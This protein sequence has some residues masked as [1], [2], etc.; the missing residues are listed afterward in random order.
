MNLTIEMYNDSRVLVDLEKQELSVN[1]VDEDEVIKQLG[2]VDE[3]LPRLDFS[4]I[5]EYVKEQWKLREEEEIERHGV[6]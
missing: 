5:V 1:N 3:I 6:N 4:D 2:G